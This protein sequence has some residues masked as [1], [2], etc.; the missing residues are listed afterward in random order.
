MLA[1]T[2]SAP[3]HAAERWHPVMTGMAGDVKVEKFLDKQTLQRKG[4]VVEV[5]LL[6][7]RS[8]GAPFVSAVDR[9]K[10]DCA[11]GSILPRGSTE[12]AGPMAT[13]NVVKKTEY[14]LPV[15]QPPAGSATEVIV[16]A[17]CEY[18]KSR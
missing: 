9:Y 14:S 13:G 8:K 3:S 5:Q 10:V 15:I 4:D 6:D 7:N 18:S 1:A 12:Y 17:V 2:L 16:K 11:A